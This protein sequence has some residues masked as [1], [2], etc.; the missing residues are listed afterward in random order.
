MPILSKEIE[1]KFKAELAQMESWKDLTGSQFTKHLAIFIA[2]AVE[3]AAFKAERAR[4]EAFIDTALNR[5][6]IL[7]HGEGMEFMPRK[8]IPAEGKVAITNQ[9]EFPF[10]ILRESE[11][12]SDSQVIFTVTETVEVA[13]GETV[14]AAIQ[15]R[16]HNSYE[17]VVDEEKPFYEILLDRSISRN[18][19]SF[20]VFVS[21]KGGEYEEWAYD[22]L[23]TNSW[24]YSKVYDEFYHFT[25]QIG[26][27]F[28]NGDFGAIPAQGAK[29][30]VETVETEGNFVLLEK[31]ALWPVNEIRDSKR[32]IANAKFTVSETIQNGRSQ[33]STEEMRRDLH[34]APV[35]NERIVWDD[36]YKYFLR[37]RFPDIVFAV[38]WGEEESEKMWG[39]NLE[40]I[41]QIYICAW[42]P[43]REIKNL[44]MAAIRQVPFMCRNFKWHE[45]E[46]IRF[47]LEITGRVLKDRIISEVV[48]DVQ[49]QLFAAYGRES[50]TRRDVVRLHEIYE[51]IQSTGHFAKDTGAWFEVEVRGQHKAELIYQMISIDMDA[52]AIDLAYIED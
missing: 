21:E 32:K 37:R 11:F 42:S 20:K 13:P 31:Q 15:Q 29:V 9:G 26:I 17:F 36:D 45:P 10:T 16:S 12:M 51:V 35:Y 27:R 14:V 6:S 30:L 47:S 50:A 3:D 49:T 23:L 1:E 28:G 44:C 48:E 7:A 33:E 8:P 18:V 41:N 46:H 2:W 19:V 43:Q 4:H 24:S 34:Y 22:R 5:S 25:D 39:Y 40:H 38:A 52:T